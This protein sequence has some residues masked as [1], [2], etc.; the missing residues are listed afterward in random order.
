MIELLDP[1]QIKPLVVRGNCSPRTIEAARCIWCDQQFFY[2]PSEE[3]DHHMN[4]P[5]QVPLQTAFVYESPLGLSIITAEGRM[6][7]DYDYGGEYTHDFVHQVVT[8]RDP[9]A[10]RISFE[11]R[12][13]PKRAGELRGLFEQGIIWAPITPDL[14]PFKRRFRDYLQHDGYGENREV[15]EVLRNLERMGYKLN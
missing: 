14:D 13:R 12:L 15:Y 6:L 8:C 2:A 1:V 3:V 5:R 10:K 9:S 11:Q 4:I 7:T